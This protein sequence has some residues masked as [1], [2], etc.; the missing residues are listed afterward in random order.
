MLLKTINESESNEIIFN[1]IDKDEIVLENIL[2]QLVLLEDINIS[3]INTNE[4]LILKFVKI[5]NGYSL[6]FRT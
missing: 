1:I 4:S 3:T 5:E 2:S 6:I